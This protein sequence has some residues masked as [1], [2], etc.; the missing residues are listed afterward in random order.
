MEGYPIAQE[1]MYKWLMHRHLHASIIADVQYHN[2]LKPAQ[3]KLDGIIAKGMRRLETKRGMLCI[4]LTAAWAST[5]SLDKSMLKQLKSDVKYTLATDP[6][7]R[8]RC[9]KKDEETYETIADIFGVLLSTTAG[10]HWDAEGCR[11]LLRAARRF[12][13]AV[14]IAAEEYICDYDFWP[15]K[16]KTSRVMYAEDFVNHKIINVDTNQTQSST[17]RL[18]RDDQGRYGLKLCV[19][20]PALRRVNSE[21]GGK[22]MLEKATLLAKFMKPEKPGQS[23]GYGGVR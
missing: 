23:V 10:S 6:E 14:D 8:R 21:P 1:A 17:R 15:S 19:D 9:D 20:H 13:D 2:C 7:L 12:K 16:P 18:Q 22:L 11:N 5:L 3:N 4:V